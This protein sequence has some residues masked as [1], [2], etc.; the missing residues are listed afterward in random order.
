[1]APTLRYHL[2]DEGTGKRVWSYDNLQEAKAKV[3]QRPEGFFI[4]D[5]ERGLA[6]FTEDGGMTWEAEDAVVSRATEGPRYS[7]EDLR[8]GPTPVSVEDRSWRGYPHPDEM[9]EM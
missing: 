7:P 9:T 5:E 2:I 4:F 3:S 1:M 6:I 8:E